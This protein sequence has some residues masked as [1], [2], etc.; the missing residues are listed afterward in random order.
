MIDL[1]PDHSPNNTWNNK[2]MKS[3][4]YICI[5]RLFFFLNHGAGATVSLINSI[6]GDCYC[7]ESSSKSPVPASGRVWDEAV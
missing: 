7:A 6:V 3:Y 2:P 1:K 4:I 5:V